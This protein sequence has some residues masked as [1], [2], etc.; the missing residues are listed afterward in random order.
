VREA[1]FYRQC[2]CHPLPHITEVESS[3]SPPGAIIQLIL[4]GSRSRTRGTSSPT[5]ILQPLSK[6]RAGAGAVLGGRAG[7][8]VGKFQRLPSRRIHIMVIGTGFVDSLSVSSVER[9]Q[10][11]AI[12]ARSPCRI[13]TNRSGISL[14]GV[15]A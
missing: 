7:L 13:S 2:S 8:V 4:Q 1:S 15:A 10:T 9:N 11:S 6:R 12:A 3:S 14:L 5:T